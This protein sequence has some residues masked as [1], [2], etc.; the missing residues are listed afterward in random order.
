[1][2]KELQQNRGTYA[3]FKNSMAYITARPYMARVIVHAMESRNETVKIDYGVEEEQRDR[4]TEEEREER[5][6]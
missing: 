3:C 6:D 1:M 4:E 2:H 5:L